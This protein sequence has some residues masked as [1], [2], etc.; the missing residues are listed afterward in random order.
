MAKVR[1][2]GWIGLLV[3]VMLIGFA[4]TAFGAQSDSDALVLV[5]S[6]PANNARDV[7]TGITIVLDFNKNVVA[8]GVR[9]VNANAVTLWEDDSKIPADIT[10]TDESDTDG[11][12]RI[13]VTPQS[14]LRPGKTYTL[15]IDTT[16]SAKDGAIMAGPAQI[17]FTTEETHTAPPD[18]WI[19]VIAGSVAALAILIFALLHRRARRRR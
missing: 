3:A 2:W 15:R 12:N 9:T 5:S 16:L 19:F 8:S 7:S 4:G 17:S 18:L 13:V 10:M 11:R 6:T 14:E 1:Q